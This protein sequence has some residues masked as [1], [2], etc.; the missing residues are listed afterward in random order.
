MKESQFQRKFIAEL[1]D[2]FEDC[3]V[4]KNDPNYIQ[5]MPDL[6]IFY[7]DKYAML[8]CKKSLKEQHQ[9]NQDYYI[10]KFNTMAYAS[11]VCPE[12]KEQVI[13]ELIIFLK[14]EQ[15]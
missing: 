9:P 2:I 6:V 12:N 11:F 1:K 7:K 5:G 8:E 4:L 15:K 14:G 10:T 3:V 13:K